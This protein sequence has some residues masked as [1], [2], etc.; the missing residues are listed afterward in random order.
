MTLF[1][2]LRA[3]ILDT[4][5]ILIDRGDLPKGLPLDAVAIEAPRDSL[6][7]DLSSNVAMVL[8]NPSGQSPRA[9][10]AMLA[11]LLNNDPRLADVSVAGPGFLNMRLA[12]PVWSEVVRTVVSQGAKYGHEDWGQGRR[13][14]VEFV[15]ANPTGP[16][17]ASVA[18][19]AVYGDV[20]ARLLQATGHDVT[21]EYYVNDGGLQV[22]VLARSVY[23]RYLEAL[24][25]EVEFDDATFPGGY[26]IDVGQA[27]AEKV[28]NAYRDQP[29]AVWL[30][31]VRAFSINAMMQL[32]QTD[33]GRL[34]VHMDSFFSE[35]SLYGTGRISAAI[36][37]LRKKDLIYQGQLEAVEGAHI[38]DMDTP[39]QTLFR[40]T[41]HG[42][43]SDRPVKKSD[44]SWAYFAP[45]IAYHFDKISRGFDELVDVFNSDHG[46]Y[47]KRMKAAVSALSDGHVPLT[48]RL[49]QMVRVMQDGVPVRTL[50]APGSFLT[51][52]DLIDE[53]GSD[54]LRFALIY[55]KPDMPLDLDLE[56]ALEQARD[57][58]VFNVQYANSR[59]ASL[60]RQIDP[61]V[62]LSTYLDLA[63]A[64]PLIL[65]IAEWPRV[66]SVATRLREPHRVAV[67]LNDLADLLH[68]N[69]PSYRDALRQFTENGGEQATI[70]GKIATLRAVSVVIHSGLDI[71]GVTP[72]AEM[73]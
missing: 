71:L 52:A 7:G 44:G 43:D 24:G 37:D 19:S 59:A 26:L 3:L 23:L 45:D 65:K 70:K 4:V 46:G 42:D 39:V 66:V 38:G 58:P 67:Y 62:D 8:A 16:L 30:E 20:L 41:A 73:R 13:V 22:D 68:A 14:N 10:G 1:A 36:E 54:V 35:K 51:L 56:K 61:E 27:L 25:H 11:D 12:E 64:K 2:D 17:Q 69:W 21:R 50:G 55:R 9:L 72:V 48:V 53:L 18:R 5:S 40:S 60:L 49:M 29:E 63:G 57:N 31:E 47:V 15:S 33:L 28:G 6:H 34:G 32:V